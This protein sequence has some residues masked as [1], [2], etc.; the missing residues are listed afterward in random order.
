MQ[1]M[2]QCMVHMC[3]QLQHLEMTRA[4]GVFVWKIPEVQSK[5]RDART[6]RKTTIY[7]S[8]FYT[9]PYGYK[10]CV[11]AYLN[12][13]GVG[14]GTHLS[15]FFALMRSEYDPFLLWPFEQLVHIILM[16]Q[17][18]PGEHIVQTFKPTPESSSFQKPMCDMNVAC[19]C[20]KFAHQDVLRDNNF[21]RGDTLYIKCIV[22]PEP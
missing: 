2:A 18:R 14:R 16:N 20:P 4:N 8:P 19:G 9:R 11:G 12:G 17:C 15:L 22:D 21:T 6:G 13:D 5:Y 7:S 1:G 3:Q 10:M